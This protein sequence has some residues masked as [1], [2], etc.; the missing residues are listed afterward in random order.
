[1]VVESGR[2]VNVPCLVQSVSLQSV[3]EANVA[4]AMMAAETVPL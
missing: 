3:A 4:V 1:M 2:R